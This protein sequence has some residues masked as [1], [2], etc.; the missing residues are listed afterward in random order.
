M[1]S[2]MVGWVEE[3]MEWDVA[4]AEAAGRLGFY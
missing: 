2:S 1:M 3:G 4:E